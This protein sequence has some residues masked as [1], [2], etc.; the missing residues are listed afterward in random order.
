MRNFMRTAIVALPLLIPTLGWS[1]S[2]EQLSLQP[3]SKLW[4]DGGS[5]VKNWSCKAGE[6]VAVVDGAPNAI[7]QVVGGEK[8]VRSVKVTVPSEKMD[9]GNGTMNDHMK[10]ALKVSDHPSIE[11]KMTGYDVARGADG[12]SGT[13]NG[14]LTLGG[15]TKPIAIAATGKNEGGALRVNGTYEL[16]MTDYELK[17]PTLMFGR[18]KVRDQVSVKFDLLLKN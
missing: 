8:G 13:L 17:P 16:T 6:V 14:T 9:C 15:V 5:T 18:I 2:P 3:E 4:V 7:A 1:V 11:F 10:K 12:V